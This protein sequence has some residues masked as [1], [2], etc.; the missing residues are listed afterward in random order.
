MCSSDLTV[1]LRSKHG[2]LRFPVAQDVSLNARQI[3]NF[4]YF[5]EELFGNGDGCAVH[6]SGNPS[7]KC[8]FLLAIKEK[9]MDARLG[10]PNAL[11]QAAAMLLAPRKRVN[12]FP[13]ELNLAKE[14]QL[15]LPS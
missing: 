15:L 4:A 9:L 6:G 1:F 12:R 14:Q 13:Q 10:G 2:E 3:A 11:P 5:E 7:G 8:P